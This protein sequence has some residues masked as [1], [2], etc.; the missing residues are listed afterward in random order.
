[1]I[2]VAIGNR[3]V[4]ECLVEMG[5]AKDA[6]LTTPGFCTIEGWTNAPCMKLKICLQIIFRWNSKFLNSNSNLFLRRFD[7]SPWYAFQ[8]FKLFSSDNPTFWEHNW[9]DFF[10]ETKKNKHIFQAT[11]LRPST[12]RTSTW[13]LQNNSPILLSNNVHGPPSVAPTS[14][15]VGEG[16]L[17]RTEGNFAVS[18]G[19]ANNA[20]K[21]WHGRRWLKRWGKTL[22]H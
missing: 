20:Q 2:D 6:M 21:H 18:S 3:K 11:L 8:S 22:Q 12:T 19:L 16:I 7:F 1:M 9:E 4:G 10:A 15:K 14:D 5:K 17:P 13:R